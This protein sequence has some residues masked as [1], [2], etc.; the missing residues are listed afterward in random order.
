MQ[1]EF[2]DLLVVLGCLLFSVARS[3][4]SLGWRYAVGVPM[5]LRRGEEC[6]A[7]VFSKFLLDAETAATFSWKGRSILEK[8]RQSQ[9]QWGFDPTKGFAGQDVAACY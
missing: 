5:L 8:N 9:S 1:M 7:N 4:E 6:V 2:E 3:N